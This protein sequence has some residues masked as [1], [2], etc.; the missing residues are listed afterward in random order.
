MLALVTGGNRG[1]GLSI[2]RSLAKNGMDIVLV[3]RNRK[4]LDSAKEELE[5]LKV[6]VWTVVCDVSEDKQVEKLASEVKKIGAPDILINNA[7]VAYNRYFEENSEEEIDRMIDVNL[8]GLIMVTWKLL[9][10]MEEGL[11]IN[12]SSDAGK[13]GFPGLAVYCATKFGVIGFT[14]ALAEELK[15]TRI[16]AYTIC[17]ADTQTDMWESLFPGTPATYQPEDVAKEV[18]ELIKNNKK[19]RP[20]SAISVQKD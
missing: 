5:G 16:R 17:P 10:L 11:L 12:I 14:E 6:R 7:A 19:I 20:G 1:I 18:M 3:G 4:T 13:Q 15:D 8:R 9:P 2:A